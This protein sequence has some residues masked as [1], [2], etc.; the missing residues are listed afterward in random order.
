M[1]PA[2]KVTMTRQPYQARVHESKA[3]A[4][5]DR[6]APLTSTVHSVS[7]GRMVKQGET[8]FFTIL[9][10]WSNTTWVDPMLSFCMVERQTRHKVIEGPPFTQNG[11]QF[12]SNGFKRMLGS[13]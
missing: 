5:G 3:K 6:N 13:R 10:E 12:T 1:V 4:I 2:L 8:H 9:D 11:S 7:M